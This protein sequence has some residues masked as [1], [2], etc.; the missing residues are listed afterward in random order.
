MARVTDW[1]RRESSGTGQTT[2]TRRAIVSR[3]SRRHSQARW[4]MLGRTTGRT[5]NA[6]IARKRPT[7]TSRSP[8]EG[9]VYRLV[10]QSSRTTSSWMSFA[11]TSRAPISRRPRPFMMKSPRT[12]TAPLRQA[13]LL[14]NC[15]PTRRSAGPSA[16]D[17]Q[18]RLLNR[19]GLMRRRS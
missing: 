19:E 6:S 4:R 15:R 5:R 3:W 2:G 16:R 17:C 7:R 8:S 11:E 9:A 1:T 13:S 14:I 18:R 12:S 10:R